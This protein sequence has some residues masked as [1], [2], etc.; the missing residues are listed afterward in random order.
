M[1][2][3]LRISHSGFALKAEMKNGAIYYDSEYGPC[4]GSGYYIGVSNNCKANTNSYTFLGYGY[5]KDLMNRS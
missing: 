1:S 2:G 4:F 3:T 5:T